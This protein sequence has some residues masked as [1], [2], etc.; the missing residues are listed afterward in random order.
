[1]IELQE[2]DPYLG[3][4][5]AAGGP[6][7]VDANTVV[8]IALIAFIFIIY[9]VGWPLIRDMLDNR[10]AEIRDELDEAKQLRIQAENLLKEYRTKHEAALLEAQ[11]IVAAAQKDAE[12]LKEKASVELENSLKRR[13]EAAKA[14]I[15]QAETAAIVKAQTSVATQAIAAAQT[16]L[17]ENLDPKA[18]AKLIDDAIGLVSGR[19]H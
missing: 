2:V 3:G 10:I 16:I 8:M 14:R 17:A 13:E 15:R 18:D 6:W 11:A 9:R 1:M 5:F 19:L 4:L 7:I 12:A